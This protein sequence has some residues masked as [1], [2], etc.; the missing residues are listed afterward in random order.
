MNNKSS[1]YDPGLINCEINPF[2]L[3]SLRFLA[4]LN[5]SSREI[6]IQI[7]SLWSN[8]DK[9]YFAAEIKLNFSRSD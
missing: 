2:V 4:I 3:S 9:P 7:I 5:I 1:L 6:G 8:I